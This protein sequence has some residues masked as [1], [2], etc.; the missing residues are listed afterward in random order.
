MPGAV[1]TGMV[2]Q[3]CVSVQG[4]LANGTGMSSRRAFRPLEEIQVPWREDFVT[5]ESKLSDGC[6]PFS[7]SQ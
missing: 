7:C 5:R 4:A 6:L 2:K 3:E 1:G